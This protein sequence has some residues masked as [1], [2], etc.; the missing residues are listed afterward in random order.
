MWGTVCIAFHRDRWQGYCGRA[1][2]PVS[3]SANWDS[4]SASAKFCL[5]DPECIEEVQGV[6]TKSGWFRLGGMALE[7]N[8]VS[9]NPR[10]YGMR[11]R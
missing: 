10:R 9:P 6:D 2:I 5:L 3:I 1:S 11:T 8:R 4:P 7:R